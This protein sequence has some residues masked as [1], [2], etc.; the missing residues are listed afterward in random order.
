MI[1]GEDAGLEP[2]FAD[3]WFKMS[4]RVAV[5]AVDDSGK[6]GRM[7]GKVSVLAGGSSSAI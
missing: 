6:A 1:R 3:G 7:T 4:V 2:N 5:G